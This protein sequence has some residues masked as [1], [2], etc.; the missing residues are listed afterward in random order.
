MIGRPTAMPASATTIG[1]AIASTDPNAI[2][3]MKIA[4][5]MPMP[6][7]DG[8]DGRSDCWMSWPPSRTSSCGVVCCSASLIICW[9]TEFGMSCDFV[10]SCAFASA[11]VPD[12]EM[13]PGVVY[14]SLTLDTCATR[15]ERGD[16]RPRLLLRPRGR[17]STACPSSR[18]ARASPDCALKF[19]ASRL[20]ALVDSVFGALKFVVKFVPVADDEHVDADERERPERD[21]EAATPVTEAGEGAERHGGRP[22]RRRYGRR[23]AR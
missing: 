2:S 18:P 4:A 8:S 23:V 19:A 5:R 9:P 7:L 17:A 16:E 20:V 3:K 21:D 12:F 11:T 13:P 1:S 22:P 10:S 15:L 14:G 6:S